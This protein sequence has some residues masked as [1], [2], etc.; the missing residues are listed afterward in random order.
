MSHPATTAARL[1]HALADL[2]SPVDVSRYLGVPSGTLANWRYLGRGPAFLRVGR[3]VR[4]RTIDVTAWV[5]AQLADRAERSGS[6]QERGSR[7]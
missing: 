7:T 4:Y 5:E 3:R 1:P 2:M 6:Y